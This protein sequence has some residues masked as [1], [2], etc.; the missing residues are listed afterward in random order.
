M[1]QATLNLTN[2]GETMKKLHFAALAT[3]LLATLATLPAMAIPATAG[4]YGGSCRFENPLS[5]YESCEAWSEAG[6][7]AAQCALERAMLKCRQ[8]FNSDCVPQG[9]VY[10]TIISQ[11]FIGYK[12]CEARVLVH[13]FR[14]R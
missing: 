9:A 10:H 4:E 13:G 8:D 14:L 7:T 3:S 12:A 2:I 6:E 1:G 11:E 5:S